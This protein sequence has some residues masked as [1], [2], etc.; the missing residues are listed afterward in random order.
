VLLSVCTS[1]SSGKFESGSKLRKIC[2]TAFVDVAIR[3]TS[4]HEEILRLVNN[5]AIAN[6]SLSQFEISTSFQE[7]GS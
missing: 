3:T 7:G 4:A 2:Q 5:G 6:F 1:L